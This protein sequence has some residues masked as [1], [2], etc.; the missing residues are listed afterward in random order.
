[1]SNFET[2]LT[3]LINKYSLENGSDIPDYVIAAYLIKCFENLNTL[4]NTRDA[5]FDFKPFDKSKRI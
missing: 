3:Y 4:V 1:M 5:W 2:E